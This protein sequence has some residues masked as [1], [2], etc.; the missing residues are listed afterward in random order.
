MYDN[1]S[2]LHNDHQGVYLDNALPNAKNKL[3][4]NKYN[5]VN[6]IRKIYNRDAWFENEES[7]EAT[8]IL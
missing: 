8:K 6:L 4:G 7:T 3:L 2:E 1:S 5:P